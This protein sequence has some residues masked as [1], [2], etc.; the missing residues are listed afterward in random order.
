MDGTKS[1]GSESEQCTL[2]HILAISLQS[3]LSTQSQES[4][5]IACHCRNARWFEPIFELIIWI[6]RTEPDISQ[7]DDQDRQAVLDGTAEDSVGEMHCF[8]RPVL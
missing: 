7:S 6:I 2:R 4:L 1:Q 3:A 8:V 5:R